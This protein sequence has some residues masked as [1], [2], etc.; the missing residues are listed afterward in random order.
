VSNPKTVFDYLNYREYLKNAL[1][2]KG[3]DRGARAKLAGALNCQGA[4][5]SLV[6]GGSSHFS[7]EHAAKISRFLNHDTEE[8]DYFL[9]LVH[10]ARA[11][12]KDLETYYREKIQ[13]IQIR[14]REI[15]ERVDTTT[16]LSEADQL[17]YYSSWHFTAIHMCLMVPHL[18][19]KSAIAAALKLPQ[20]RVSSVLNFLLKTGLAK[21]SGNRYVCGPTRIH[22]PAD[23]PLVT[24]HHSNWRLQAL[25]SMDSFH[26]SSLHYSSVMSLSQ[27]A[28]EKIRTILLQAIET[29]EPIIKEAKE[30]TVCVLAMDLFEIALSNPR[31]S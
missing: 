26:P 2:V 6:L 3:P 1:P 23:S 31:Q 16:Q 30:E 20:S 5:I 10:L 8:R 19:D 4:F 21:L 12:S 15:K 9:L 11:G 28:I 13:G 27:E 29:S 22:L 17:T 25:Q 14:R 24:K 18:Q 7:L